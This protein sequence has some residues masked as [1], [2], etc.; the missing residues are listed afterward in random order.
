MNKIYAFMMRLPLVYLVF[1]SMLVVGCS[2]SGEQTSAPKSTKKSIRTI[3]IEPHAVINSNVY[4]G[5]VVA[6]RQT[7]LASQVLGRVT[8][9]DVTVGEQVKKGQHLVRLDAE[10]ANQA[11]LASTSQ[12]ASARA[13]LNLAQQELDRQKQLYAKNY[14][15]QSALENAEAVYKS[16][17]AQVN[18]QIAQ[19]GVAKTQTDFHLVKAPYD[20]VVSVVPITLGDMASP[21]KVLLTLYD[22]SQ[23]RV[24][25]AI[26]QAVATTIEKQSARSAI[27]SISNVNEIAINDIQILP[28]AD[29]ATH[30]RKVWLNLPSNLTN[31]APGMNATVN[32]P[33]GAEATEL[34]QIS[35]PVT[36]LVKHSE[37]TGVYVISQSG[38]PLLRQLRLGELH[39]DQ[40]EVLSG[41][42]EG[43]EIAIEPQTVT[44]LL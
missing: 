26:P 34:K 7:D 16:A 2:P 6:V 44:G 22:A 17:K 13:Q 9:L 19:A 40:V 3:K 23:L 35:I 24:E 5:T 41:L 32:F 39:G 12:L 20:A 42:S 30:T 37:M 27:V 43:E 11:A 36:A 25:V 8:S 1:V 29:Q 21:G 38:E 14:I 33:I 31:V 28:A 10:A 15:S 18:A 4:D